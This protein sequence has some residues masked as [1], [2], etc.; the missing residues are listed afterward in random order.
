MRAR[1]IVFELI[2]NAIWFLGAMMLMAFCL[3]C[4]EEIK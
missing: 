3:K 1:K 4:I 2:F